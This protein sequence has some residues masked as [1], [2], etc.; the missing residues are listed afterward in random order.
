MN[1]R[2]AILAMLDGKTVRVAKSG[3]PLWRFGTNFETSYG[4]LIW[5][6]APFSGNN[7]YE[8]V[9]VTNPH[10]VGTYAWAREEHKRGREVRSDED[11]YDAHC[12][13]E[14]YTFFP[15]EFEATNWRHA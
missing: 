12:P 5:E 2:E 1:G 4:G 11:V 15:A 3:A 14:H 9:E 7:E 13:W 6:A 8:L 10:P